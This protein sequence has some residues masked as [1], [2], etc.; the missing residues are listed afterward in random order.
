MDTSEKN[1]VLITC[2]PH[3]VEY[4]KA[5]LQTLGFTPLS[6]H[7]AGVEISAS[8]DDTMLL[9]LSLRTAYNVLYLLKAFTC[10]DPER[11][12]QQTLSIAWEDI[13]SPEEYFTVISR[14]ENPT[15]NN[16]MYP[17]LKVK[18]AIVDRIAAKT[19]LRPTS[20]NERENAVV[21]LY[22]KDN[23]CWLY[24]N[25]SGV[26]LS[27]RSYRKMPH[28]APMRESLAA[29]V[30]SETGYDGTVPLV[31]PMCGSG[32]LAIEAALIATQRPPGLLR[33]NFAFMHLK[34]F[35]AK[36]LKDLRIQLKKQT[37]KTMP[38]PIIATDIDP[39][40]VDA[41]RKNALTAG[42]DHLI[43]FSVCDFADTPIPSGDGIIILNPE[44]GLRLGEVRE[45][46]V[47]YKRIGDFFKQKCAGYT[48]FIFTGNLDLAKKI[49]LKTSRK[50]PF[51][52]ADIECRLIEYKLYQGS[53]KNKNTP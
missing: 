41:A 7:K 47:T 34:T 33:T 53:K 35:D 25:T 50:I 17:N 15:I 38:A 16:T 24:L 51:F 31:N 32:T 1:T 48:G 45:L 20:G 28:K 52:N 42:V 40:A 9:N 8:I 26:K 27:D 19:G 2:S 37:S 14:V 46:E 36:K 43:E 12:Y 11:L 30:I 21:N 6:W 10:T 5:E 4:L 49:G 3:L 44:Y 13:I 29:A 23:R 22:W 39:A 18:D